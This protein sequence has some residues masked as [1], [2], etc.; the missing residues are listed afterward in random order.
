MS[1]ASRLRLPAPEAPSEARARFVRAGFGAAAPWYDRLTRLLS[2]GLDGWWRRLCLERCELAPGQALLDLATGTGELAIQA[3]RALGGG[4]IA[5]GLDSCAEMLGEARAKVAQRTVARVTWVQGRAEALPFQRET[6]DRVTVGF[7]LR[8]FE[9]GETLR[10]IARVLKPGGRFVV[11]EWT[12]PEPA[13]ARLLLLGYMRRVVPPLVGLISRDPRV[14]DLASYLP[15]SI[16]GFMS[17][18]ALSRSIQ[19][20]GLDPA[21]RQDYMF[22]LVSICVGVKGDRRAKF[23]G[24]RDDGVS[25][26]SRGWR[27]RARQ[28][29]WVILAG[30]T[31]LAIVAVQLLL[32]LL[33]LL[34]R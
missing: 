1:T 34:S 18:A 26:V 14:A 31:V 23:P 20:V 10:E 2:F 6:F 12:R 21:G 17:G 33:D 22:G 8:H 28:Q 9:L 13:L 30:G 7:A 27:E 15:Q 19:S 4:G 5:V 3:R 24:E 16:D 29:W 25:R 11:L 32:A